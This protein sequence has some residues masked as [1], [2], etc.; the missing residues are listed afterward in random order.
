MFVKGMSQYITPKY[1]KLPPPLLSFEQQWRYKCISQ[2]LI[3]KYDKN[4]LCLAFNLLFDS[5]IFDYN[6]YYFLIKQEMIL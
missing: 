2:I 5:N 4:V 6:N 3:F 1:V